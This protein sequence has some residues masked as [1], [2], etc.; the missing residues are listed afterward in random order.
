M[1]ISDPPYLICGHPDAGPM[2]TYLKAIRRDQL[3]SVGPRKEDGF[4]GPEG[5]HFEQH[6]QR[7]PEGDLVAKP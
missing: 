3:C 4:C 6:P 1:E 5:K 7:T 2:G